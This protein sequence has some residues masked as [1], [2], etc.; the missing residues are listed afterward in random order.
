M[1]G[2]VGDGAEVAG[3]HLARA[4]HSAPVAQLLAAAKCNR[5][6]R[7]GVELA[8]ERGRLGNGE[9]DETRQYIELEE[10]IHTR[11]LEDA[12]ALFGLDVPLRP[13][14]PLQQVVIRAMVV[15]PD[16]ASLPLVLC[17]EVVG[18]VGFQLLQEALSLFAG[19]PE[20]A[21]R[22][23]ALVGEILLDEMGHVVFNRAMLGRAQLTAARALLPVVVHASVRDV[24]ELAQ[25]AGG[26]DRFL[27]R[28]Q[29]FAEGGPALPSPLAFAA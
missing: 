20:V 7:F 5:G 12:C 24:P 27:A 10:L 29:R 1:C 13:P 14:P 18:T 9:L 21:A 23:K 28:V 25:L 15:L 8:L 3:A 4:V 6:E 17:G 11:L 19:E 22:L 26:T 16:A 2:R